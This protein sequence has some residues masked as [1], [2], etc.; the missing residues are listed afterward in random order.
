MRRLLDLLDF[1]IQFGG[2]SPE[3]QCTREYKTTYQVNQ[4]LTLL[5]AT[6]VLCRQ[7]YNVRMSP[8]Q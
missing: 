5:F 1:D 8:T 7:P 4:S 6:M 3:A 2:D